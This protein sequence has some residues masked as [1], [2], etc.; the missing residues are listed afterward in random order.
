MGLGAIESLPARAGIVHVGGASFV[1]PWQEFRASPSQLGRLQAA[2]MMA[3]DATAKAAL[4]LQP[5]VQGLLTGIETEMAKEAKR[6]A[7]IPE[8]RAVVSSRDRYPEE[9]PIHLVPARAL[10]LLATDNGEG[11]VYDKGS[12]PMTKIADTTD[13]DGLAKELVDLGAEISYRTLTESQSSQRATAEFYVQR[14]GALRER[15][16]EEGGRV[17]PEERA[18]AVSARRILLRL[19]RELV[20]QEEARSVT[21]ATHAAGSQQR[22]WRRDTLAARRAVLETKGLQR[23]V[24][25]AA[26][27]RFRVH[28]RTVRAQDWIDPPSRGS[29]DGLRNLLENEHLTLA[30]YGQGMRYRRLYIATEK[31][32]RSALGG[33]GAGVQEDNRAAEDWGAPL[34]DRKKLEKV[35]TDVAKSNGRMLNTLRRVAGEGR[36]INAISAAGK[37]SDRIQNRKALTAALQL[38]VDHDAAARVGSAA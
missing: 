20:E 8:G 15:R 6:R 3:A 21:R 35:I 14:H 19:H 34:A 2:A 13:P 25:L 23:K 1:T 36:T 28:L 29:D 5:A 26:V 4:A 18:A 17:T 11:R 32:L 7:K 30:Q 24:L 12:F 31:N 22:R 16:L 33:D 9:W 10:G 37:S 38:L 27:W